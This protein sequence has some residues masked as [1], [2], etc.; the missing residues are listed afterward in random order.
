MDLDQIAALTP[1]FS[2]ADLANLVNEAALAATRR[3]AAAVSGDDFTRAVERIVAG[4][5]KRSRIMNPLERKIVAYHELGHAFVALLRPGAETVHKVS[6]IPRGIGALGYTIQRPTEDRYLMTRDELHDKIAVL[7]AG[8]ASETL[9]FAQISTGAAD[10]LARATDIARS[11]VTRFGMTEALGRVAYEDD[12]HR[13]LGIESAAAMVERRYSEDT[14]TKID[15]AVRELLDSAFETAFAIL[16][17]RRATLDRA[18]ELLLAKETLDGAELRQ[19]LGSDRGSAAPEQSG[20]A[21]ERA[22]AEPAPGP[23]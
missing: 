10:D 22:K 21:P 3:N 11:M 19:V 8:R 12:R 18:A 7:L 23:A 13:F 1:G 4:L 17:A 9:V 20:A 6:I 14:A 2:G 16:Q 5:E 15:G